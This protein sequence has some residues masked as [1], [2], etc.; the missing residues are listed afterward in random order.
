MNTTEEEWQEI[1]RRRED[2]PTG[3]YSMDQAR[4]GKN[5]KRHGS[6]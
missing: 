2:P 6:R 5:K 3:E 1:V 4:Y